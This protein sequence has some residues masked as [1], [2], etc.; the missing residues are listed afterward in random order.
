[1]IHLQRRDFLRSSALA[2][3]LT[4]TARSNAEATSLEEARVMTVED[5][6]SA[7]KL[8]VTL[9]HEHVMVD[10]IGADKASSDRY[11]SDEVFQIM[12]PYMKQAREVGCQTF[13]DCTPAHLGRD[14]EILKRLAKASGLRIMT[15]T[16]FYG[17]RQG[18]FLPK[19]A[20]QASVDDLADRWTNEWKDGI[21]ETGIRP[22]LIKIGVDKGELSD[23]NRKLIQAASKCHLNTGLTIA[24]HTGDGKAALQ[25]VEHLKK[26]GASPNGTH[27]KESRHRDDF[28][29]GICAVVL[30]WDNGA[31]VSWPT[32]IHKSSFHHNKRR[33]STERSS[34][35]VD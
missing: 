9:P 3:V 30:F 29:H 23:V 11:K 27:F 20:F 28:W 16:G 6:I 32:N 8:G 4:C 7:A 22:G 15:N 14:P 2:T 13:V 34:F 18:K 31:T 12:L 21:G 10:F 1:M 24:A 19:L 35:S 25:Q 17:A 5:E 26:S 33:S